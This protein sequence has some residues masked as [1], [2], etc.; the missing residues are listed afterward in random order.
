MRIE[1]RESDDVLVLDLDG[2]LVSGVGEEALRGKVNEAVVEGWQKLLL[3]LSQVTRIDS[4]GIGELVASIKLA[5]R[6]GAQ[7]KLVRIDTR[8]KHILNLSKILP[9]LDFYET[10]EE[11]L[12]AFQSAS[13][14][15]SQE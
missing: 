8:V 11:A 12:A 15:A 10:E 3:N 14:E 5:E 7:V 9:L 4:M 13:P 1:A 6:F 2:P